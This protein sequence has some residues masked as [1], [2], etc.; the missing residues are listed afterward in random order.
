MAPEPEPHHAAGART[1]LLIGAAG[2]LIRLFYLSEH[3]TS[4][5]FGVPILDEKYYDAV[6]R[7]LAAGQDVGAIN[8]GFRPLLY[9]LFLAGAYRL[10]GDWGGVLAI[11]LQHLLGVATALLA[12]A[13][14]AR[15]F[16]RP[17]AGA[18]AGGLYVAAGPPLFFEGELLIT[19]LF[20][21]LSAL[22][23]LSM[24][25]LREDG[26]AL[27]WLAA[28]ALV[29]LAAAARPNALTVAA[30]FVI[31]A[32]VGRRGR[33]RGRAARAGAALAGTL[34]GLVL[35]ALVQAPLV[36]G[37][38]LVGGSGGVNFYLGNKRTADGRIPR[39]D[40]AVTYGEEYRDS[41][42]VFAEEV[43]R[44]ETGDGAP[45][46]APGKISRYWL[47]RGLAEIRQD[48]GAWAALMA[49]KV[50]FFF[51]NREIPNNKSFAFF[52]DHESSVLGF[53]PVGWWLL[54]ALAPLGAVFAWRRG[55]RRRLLWTG[56]FVALYASGVV[57]FFVN[58]RYR[59]PVWPAMAVLAGG[60]ALAL[61]DAWRGRRFGDI[62]R[63][64]AVA[65]AAAAV[66]LVNWLGVP[67]ESYARD[68]FF[69]SIAQL[70]KGNLEEAEADARS[71]V[72]LEPTDAAAHFQAGTVALA[73][74]D[75]ASAASS[76]ERAAE[77]LPGEPRI[78]NNLGVALE[79]LGHPGRA[80]AHYLRALD[81]A[82]DY[83]PSL[84]NAALLELR[85]GLVE[86][87]EARVRRAGE[88]GSRSLPYLCAL[89][90]VERERGR[91]AR[92]REALAEAER[93]DAGAVRRLVEDNRRPLSPVELRQSR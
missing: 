87:A 9:P 71:S 64:L 69:R 62:G 33:F 68:F 10:A 34:L 30:A 24:S 17:A 80:Y 8:P 41:V 93:L 53:M 22:L 6:A 59:I 67:R 28:G 39:Q 38:H 18:W 49:R 58:S 40:R 12:A 37:V 21:F 45:D 79:R 89:A 86:E 52:R 75:D 1:L 16:R 15:L 29:A 61:A 27:G 56:L 65:A 76:F 26:P 85:A 70:E 44:E 2:L 3:A 81:L 92:Y 14:A 51:W 42:E 83:A 25:R 43:Y 91:E 46:V 57:L 4:A 48:P 31:F 19:S 7:V 77:L 5:F 23:L 11:S 78:W 60:G 82:G 90:F 55:D 66:S 84:V 35:F 74:G 88:L 47:G 50:W 20:T 54:F 72:A 73:R 36:G 63:G 13:A 32:A